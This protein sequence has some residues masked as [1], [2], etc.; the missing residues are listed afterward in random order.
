MTR[1]AFLAMLRLT[2]SRVRRRVLETIFDGSP[3]LSTLTTVPTN[4]WEMLM[5][6]TGVSSM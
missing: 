3:I 2:V 4:S 5:G 6:I 1:T